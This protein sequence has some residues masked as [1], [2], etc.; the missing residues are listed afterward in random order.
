MFV[1]ASGIIGANIYVASDA[2]RY[3][4]GN[5]VLLGIIAFNLVIL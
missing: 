1:Q 3:E 5:S 4:K 2:P